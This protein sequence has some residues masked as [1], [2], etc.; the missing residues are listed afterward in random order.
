MK[1][2]DASKSIR[3]SSNFGQTFGNNYEIYIG[4]CA[5]KSKSN[6]AYLGSTYEHPQ[7]AFETKEAELFLSGSN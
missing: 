6:F 2:K 3:Y 5:N 7:Y 1:T 4:N